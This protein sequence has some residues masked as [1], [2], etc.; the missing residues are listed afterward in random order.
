MHVLSIFVPPRLCKIDYS[1]KRFC[2]SPIIFDFSSLAVTAPSQST[3]LSVTSYFNR[4]GSR[5]A[6]TSKI[7]RSVIIVNGWKPLPSKYLAIRLLFL[8]LCRFSFTTQQF[9]L[10]SFFLSVLA[11]HR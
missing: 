7:E 1:G 10:G 5:T 2:I 6:A 4:G 9:L 8:L 11:F 3:L